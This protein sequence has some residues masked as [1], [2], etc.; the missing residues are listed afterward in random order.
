MGE[1]E[2][3]VMEFENAELTRIKH[4]TKFYMDARGRRKKNPLVLALFKSNGK[5][6]RNRFIQGLFNR[7]K[8]KDISEIR[9]NKYGDIL[10]VK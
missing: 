2:P 8:I 7:K 9:V 10:K 6:D 3:E 4:D 5:K 1:F